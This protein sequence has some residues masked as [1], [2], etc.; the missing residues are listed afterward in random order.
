M[1][2]AAGPRALCSCAARMSVVQRRPCGCGRVANTSQGRA[3]RTRVA[4]TNPCARRARILTSKSAHASESTVGKVPTTSTP[5]PAYRWP[6]AHVSTK[7]G[8]GMALLW[9]GGRTANTLV[10]RAGPKVAQHVDGRAPGTFR[11]L[12]AA[13]QESHA[14]QPLY[15]T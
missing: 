3:W 13:L 7:E 9:A 12:A 2:R 4:D 10:E 14:A 1:R 11:A 5:R 15:A 8:M 6:A